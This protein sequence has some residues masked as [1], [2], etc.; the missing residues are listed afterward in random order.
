[1]SLGAISAIS[2][3]AS[4]AIGYHTGAARSNLSIAREAQELAKVP[5]STQQ[6]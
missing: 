1:M 2:G 5:P 4:T 3:S 6:K